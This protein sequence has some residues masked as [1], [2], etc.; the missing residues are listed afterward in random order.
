MPTDT[1]TVVYAALLSNLLIAVTKGVAALVTGS[2]AMLS[3]AVHSLVDSG[4]EL[5]LLY[6]MHRSHLQPDREHPLGYGRELYFWSFVVAIMVFAIGAGVS[7]LQGFRA[8]LDPEPIQHVT[9]SYM[10][11]GLAFLFEGS[12]LIVSLRAFRRVKGQGS[13]WSAIRESKD[14]PQFMTLLEDS[15]A[16]CGILI[17]L[18]GTIASVHLAEPRFDGLASI[19]I[20]LL[21]AAV[22]IVLARE[23]KALLIGERADPSL[24]KAVFQLAESSPGVVCA[25]G[26]VTVQLAPDQVVAALSLQFEANLATD[27]IETIVNDLEKRLRLAHPDILLLFVK[28]ETAAMYAKATSLRMK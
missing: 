12:S 22:A 27:R 9:I 3:E 16:L 17:A 23:S 24:R 14:P 5:L 2:S 13:Y 25:N 8:V 18:A 4:N 10:V 21:L 28:P 20:G 19:G 15:A 1:K 6:G 26:L 7:L 11:L